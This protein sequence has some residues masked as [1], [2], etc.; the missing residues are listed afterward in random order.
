[1]DDTTIVEFSGRDTVSDPLT[2]LLC[3]PG[4]DP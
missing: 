1:M 3:K 4:L 2:E